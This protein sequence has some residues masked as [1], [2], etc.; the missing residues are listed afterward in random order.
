MITVQFGSLDWILSEHK[1]DPCSF[2][3]EDQLFLENLT[4]LVEHVSSCYDDC[5]F[6]KGISLIMEQLHQVCD[7]Y[8]HRYTHYTVCTN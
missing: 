3:K 6:S 8:V 5:E 2:L 7:M 4:S 1:F